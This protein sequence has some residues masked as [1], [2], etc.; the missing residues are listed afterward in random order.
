MDEADKK[1]GKGKVDG[2]DDKDLKEEDKSP[3]AAHLNTYVQVLKE[4]KV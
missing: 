1:K 2:E 3:F 4:N